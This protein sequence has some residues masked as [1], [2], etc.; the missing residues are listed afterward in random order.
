MPLTLKITIA[1][2][3]IA[4]ETAI[5]IALLIYKTIIIKGITTLIAEVIVP[6]ITGT[7][8]IM[9]VYTRKYKVLKVPKAL[10]G[11]N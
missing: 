4:L 8:I 3:I 6:I 10:K 1:I 11:L 7:I 5:I 2:A 9:P